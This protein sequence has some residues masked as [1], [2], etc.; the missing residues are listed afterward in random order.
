MGREAVVELAAA[1]VGLVVVGRLDPQMGGGV[2]GALHDGDVGVEFLERAAEAAR[3]AGDLDSGGI[4]ERLS[5]ARHRGLEQGCCEWGE[6]RNED[7]RGQDDQQHGTV[8]VVVAAAAS[9]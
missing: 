1:V 4:S 9:V 3:V 5:A 6:N 2:G 7:D 8:V